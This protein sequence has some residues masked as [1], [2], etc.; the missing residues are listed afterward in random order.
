M[1]LRHTSVTPKSLIARRSN[2][3]K[4]TGP[5]TARGKARVSLN[6]L[7]DGRH[8]VL[9][10]RAPRLRQRLIEAGD[11]EEEAVYGAIRS[12]IAQ[13]SP[14]QGPAARREIDRLALLA[15]CFAWRTH[16]RKSKLESPELSVIN[17]FWASTECGLN[18]QRFSIVDP[19]RRTGLVFWRQR[20]HRPIGNVSPSRAAST[21]IGT[22]SSN[23]RLAAELAA[24]L[25]HQQAMPA[26]APRQV[27]ENAIRCRLYRLAKPGALERHRYRVQP[28]GNPDPN[29]R[30]WK[31]FEG[32]EGA[33]WPGSK[34]SWTV[35][36]TGLR[37]AAGS[38]VTRH[39]RVT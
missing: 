27:Y 16:S 35:G 31:D 23:K 18:L 36:A 22:E 26:E 3:Q 11:I 4:S 6:A 2:A 5:R 8:A 19:W 7:K 30:N 21:K 13:A 28:D 34:E 39:T 10:S 15:W 33:T 25:L 29:L 32:N 14:I 9:A 20:R 38:S 12:R 24:K 17:K 37:A 1:P